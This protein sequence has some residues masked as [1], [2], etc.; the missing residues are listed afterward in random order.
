MADVHNKQQRSYNMSRIKGKD[1][2]PEML[3]RKFLH[4]SGY[5]S[6]LWKTDIKNRVNKKHH[7]RIHYHILVMNI[8]QYQ[9]QFFII[10]IVSFGIFWSITASKIPKE[11]IIII[12]NW[13]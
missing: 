2:K 1:T 8:F 6:C 3:V 13:D 9:S 12:K 10:I 4:T 7:A 5:S 11:T